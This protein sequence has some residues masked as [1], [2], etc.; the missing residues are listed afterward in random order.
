MP[1][2][3]AIV[4]GPCNFPTLCHRVLYYVSF[5]KLEVLVKMD[6]KHRLSLKYE[7]CPESK[8]TSRVGQYGIFLCLLWQYGRL[9]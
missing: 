8:D 2:K 7:D 1:L 5:C 4:S 3:Y 6:N 9:P